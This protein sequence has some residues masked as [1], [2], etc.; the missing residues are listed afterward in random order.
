MTRTVPPARWNE[1]CDVA[2]AATPFHRYEALTV[3]AER[4]GA[5]LHPFVGYQDGS[6]VGLFPVFERSRGP[7][8][9]LF[10]PV[11]DLKVPYLGPVLFDLGDGSPSDRERRR[12]AFLDASLSCFESRFEPRYVHVRT[13]PNFADPRPFVWRGFDLVPRHSYVVDLTPGPEALLD[14]FSSDARRNVRDPPDTVEIRE[15][16]HDAIERI[17]RRVTARHEEQGETYLVT[18]EYV[19]ELYD[20]LPDGVVRPYEVVLEDRAVGGMVTLEAGDTIYRWQGGA[21][22]DVDAPVND[23]LD[24]AIMREAI[25]R[26]IER[27]DLV[28]ANEQRL[29]D[30][31]AKFAPDL[32]TF[33]SLVAST[34]PMNLASTLYKRLR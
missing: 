29:T 21:K 18:P 11:P 9:T 27:Y 24:W 23:L 17:V 10:S 4:S 2:P 8:S 6:P 13:T 20:A 5:T 22:P 34:R 33:H 16:G 15:G 7:V 25:D 19:S 12:W 1:F 14:S 32:V 28:G 31:K 30:Y 26:G 3:L